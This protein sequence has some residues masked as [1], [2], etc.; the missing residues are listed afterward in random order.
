MLSFSFAQETIK[1][2]KTNT[3]SKVGDTIKLKV[4]YSG[5]PG[6]FKLTQFDFQYNNKL[7]SLQSRNWIVSS[8]SLKGAYNSW[9]GYK[10]GNNTQQVI[11]MVSIFDFVKQVVLYMVQT[12][13]WPVERITIQDV[14]LLLLMEMVGWSIT[15]LLK[16]NQVLTIQITLIY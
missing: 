9:N 8:N 10:W 16:I 6:T 15:L 7:L 11:L 13:D 12:S 2:N 5:T 14:F 1:I 3:V 4:E